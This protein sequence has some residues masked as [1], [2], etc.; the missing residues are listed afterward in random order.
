MPANGVEYEDLE[1]V[2][3][4][5]DPEKFFQIGAK[6]PL[7][8]KASL[9]EFLRTNVDVFAWDPY[10]AL[11]VD[12]SFIC[13]RLNVN[14]TVMPRRQ[15]PRQPSKEHAEAVRSKV[16]KLIQAGAIKEV[17]YP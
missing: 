11:G 17:F 12:P 7:Q 9:L 5:D 3:V 8:E 13:H 14:P 4:T 2:V 16:A 15:P 6:L 1:K 10:E